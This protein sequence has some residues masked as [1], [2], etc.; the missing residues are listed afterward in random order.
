MTNNTNTPL[1]AYQVSNSSLNDVNSSVKVRNSSLYSTNSSF[2]NSISKQPAKCSKSTKF[3][4]LLKGEK[5]WCNT[6]DYPFFNQVCKKICSLAIPLVEPTHHQ[7]NNKNRIN[8]YFTTADNKRYDG[9]TTNCSAAKPSRH[10]SAIFMPKIC[11][12]NYQRFTNG[13]NTNTSAL[14]SRHKYSVDTIGTNTYD[15]SSEPNKI[16]LWG[17]KLRRLN[18]VV[19]GLSPSFF[20]G[21]NKLTNCSGP[22]HHG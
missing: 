6:G 1:K 5:K 3:R 14:Q 13:I 15:G 17:N 4:P 11:L 16:P 8:E 20:A 7:L 19:N 18:T 21:D 10:S 12:T 9:T 22:I 2:S